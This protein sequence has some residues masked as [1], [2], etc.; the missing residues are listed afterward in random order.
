MKWLPFF[1]IAPFAL[2]GCVG[3]SEPGRTAAEAVQVANVR[4]EELLELPAFQY[5]MAVE[6]PQGSAILDAWGLG[7]DIALF[8][9]TNEQ[10]LLEKGRAWSWIVS[11]ESQTDETVLL[12]HVGDEVQVAYGQHMDDGHSH[13]EPGE[14]EGETLYC[15]TAPE[16]D[17]DSNAAVARMTSEPGYAEFLN[18]S[19]PATAS[20]RVEA[21]GNCFVGDVA[22]LM[23]WHTENGTELFVALEAGEVELWVETP[24]PITLYNQRDE[25]E[26]PLTAPLD[27]A[28]FSIPFQ[29]EEAGDV[30]F[31]WEL[32]ARGTDPLNQADIHLLL[33]SAAEEIPLH[34]VSGATI[35]TYG[36]TL[37]LEAGSYQ[38]VME[39]DASIP[40]TWTTETLIQ[41]H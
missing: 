20:L 21:S 1:L 26:D 16:I 15:P 39:H 30:S 27:G 7:D 38:F 11:Y 6:G 24:A 35:A 29:I 19:A 33:R 10:G 34:T 22:Y 17:P 12:V 31:L 23:G 14:Q 9:L 37:A 3:D 32:I 28:E 4:A 5:A 36:T 40:S 8:D 13:G 41:L 18:E 25:W 2:A